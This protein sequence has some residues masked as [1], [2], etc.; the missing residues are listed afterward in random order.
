MGK[1]VNAIASLNRKL[2]GI[3]RKVLGLMEID[4]ERYV[5]PAAR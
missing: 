3:Q 4:P 5:L 2:S 1:A